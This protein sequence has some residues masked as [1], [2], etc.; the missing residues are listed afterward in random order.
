[1][2]PSSTRAL[3]ALLLCLAVP[4]AAAEA[5]APRAPAAESEQIERAREELARAREELR[6]AAEALAR[7][8]GAIDRDSPRA[9]A[10]EYLSNPKRAMLGVTVDDAPRRGGESRGVLLTGI[11]P[12]GG[13]AKAGLKSGDVLIAANGKALGARED[14]ER[15]PSGKLK[16][17]MRALKPGDAVKLEYERDGKRASAT[18]IASRQDE[19]PSVLAWRDDQDFDVIV[20]P[21]PPLAPLAPMAMMF[22]EGG[23]EFMQLARLDAEL[24]PYFKTDQGVLVIK[25]PKDGSL[26]LKGGD[27]ITRLE[28]EAVTSP[29]AVWEGLAEVDGNE[30]VKAEVVRAGKTVKL[31]GTVPTHRRVIRKHIEIHESP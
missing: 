12:G 19:L 24:A 1:M 28:G 14:D 5:E 4:L 7:A 15:G 16:E 26:G 21:V 2:N 25:A 20:P 23:G 8:S 31:E 27:V 10:Y 6:R 9:K 17:I 13:A 3:A 11:T 30:P 29:V 22:A 18:V